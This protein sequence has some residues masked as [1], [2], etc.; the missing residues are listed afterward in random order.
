ML[1]AVQ[2][3]ISRAERD[4]DLI[5]HQDIPPFTALPPIQEVQLAQSAILPE[6]QSPEKCIGDGRII[7]AEMIGWGAGVAIGERQSC[8]RHNREMLTLCR[9]IQRQTGELVE[10][11]DL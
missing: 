11:G 7:F 1:D 10:S 2:K 9:D 4:N 6:L 5:Y 8:N 3:N